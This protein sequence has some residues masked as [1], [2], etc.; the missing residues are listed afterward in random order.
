MVQTFVISLERSPERR[1]KIFAHLKE[2]GLENVHWFKA[3]DG[4][5]DD[6]SQYSIDRTRFQRFWHNRFVCCS[7]NMYFSDTEYACALSHLGVYQKIVDENL[8]MALVLEDDVELDARYVDFVNNADEVVNEVGCDLLYLWY[9]DR[10]KSKSEPV[11]TKYGVQVKKVGMGKYDWFYNRRRNVNGAVA[12]IIT[13]KA[14]RHLLSLA[15]PV[16]C[17][18]D[19]LLGLLAYNKL[20]AY[21]CIPKVFEIAGV[22]TTILHSGDMAENVKPWYSRAFKKIK[23]LYHKDQISE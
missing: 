10:L 9:G 19:V 12:Y 16:R 18:S 21:K 20:N 4:K 8:P 6:L 13:N 23:S 17:Q 7:A 5:K 22:E 15:Y 3:I 14:A 11:D 2:R 1:D